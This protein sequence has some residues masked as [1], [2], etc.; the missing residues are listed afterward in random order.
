MATWLL[1]QGADVNASNPYGMTP[2]HVA[3][4]M[5]RLELARLLLE[6]GAAVNAQTSVHQ[7]PLHHAVLHKNAEMARLLLEHG[8]ALN[9]A[10]DTGRTPVDWV[11][12]KRSTPLVDVLVQHGVHWT[13]SD[14]IPDQPAVESP[15]ILVT[16]I[17][18]IDLLAPLKRGGRVGFFTPRLGVGFTVVLGQLIRSLSE[19][20]QG[21]A[22]SIG[23]ESA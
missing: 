10:D 12:L 13:R 20:H 5:R 19:L 17:K 22:V 8:A 6:H 16:G 3:V 23:L 7:T 15:A 21:Y 1:S 11:A 4:I 9:L 14:T 2:L 18:V